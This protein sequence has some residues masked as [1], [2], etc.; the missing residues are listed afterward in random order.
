MAKTDRRTVN[1]TPARAR[2]ILEQ[3]AASGYENFRSVNEDRVAVLAGDINKK[4]WQYNG[5]PI[6]IGRK[7]ELLD[8]QHRLRACIKSGKTIKTDIVEGLDPHVVEET[9]DMGQRR[10]FGQ[11]LA[12]RGE[13]YAQDLAAVIRRIWVW[14][15]SRSG[16]FGSSGGNNRA[17]SV[18]DLLGALRRHGRVRDF[19][20]AAGNYKPV[21]STLPAAFAT[22]MGTRAA[23]LDEA[24]RDDFLTGI[25]KGIDLKAGDPRLV[26]RNELLRQK[27]R[28]SHDPMRWGSMQLQAC[29][30]KAWNAWL[31]GNSVNLRA[32]RWA[33]AK[34]KFPTFLKEG[35]V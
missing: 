10:T 6:R 9:V 19:V 12:H 34:E 11:L 31:L 20:A 27:S 1:V 17:I 13:P 23:S 24:Y 14:Q 22:Y 28:P 4:A 5:D 15:H 32:I 30:I 35:D 26:L 21:I 25:G 16:G 8:G 29:T 3:S 33:S 2:E 7:G 18:S